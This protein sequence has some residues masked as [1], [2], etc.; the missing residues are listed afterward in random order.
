MNET[1]LNCEHPLT[2]NF[3]E[4]CGQKKFARIDKQYLLQELQ[5]TILHTN[6]GLFYSLK[7]LL[8]N[9]GKTARE[10]I[11]G[12]RIYHY[13]PLLLVFVL[14]GVSAF[15]SFKMFDFQDIVVRDANAK[16]EAAIFINKLN[17][18]FASY[19][20]IFTMLLLPFLAISTRLAFKKW[21]H[22]YYE[23]IV[24]NA[25]ILSVYTLLSFFVVYFPSIILRDKPE[26]YITL[27]Q[28]SI[29]LVPLILVWFFKYFYFDKSLSSIIWRVLGALGLTLLGIILL[30]IPAVIA[31]VIIMAQTGIAVFK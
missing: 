16:P 3:C 11:D 7:K 25:Y 5:Y 2:A 20:S 23:H 18:Y 6:K 19:G 4:N 22:N 27:S 31:A 10:F 15:I 17:T 21:G 13:K 12:K 28:F 9:P 30:I 29:F 14:A 26:V 24:I 8:R 1:C